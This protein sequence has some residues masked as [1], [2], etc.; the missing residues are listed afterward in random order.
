M[1]THPAVNCISF[2]GGDTGIS[3]SKKAGMVPIQVSLGPL[4]WTGRF[5]VPAS[6]HVGGLQ[7]QRIAPH[8]CVLHAAD[9]AGRQGC[10]HRMR[11]MLTI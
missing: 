6:L 11:G 4:P 10:L 8:D 2:T 3:I 5:L 7:V 1:Q 9:G